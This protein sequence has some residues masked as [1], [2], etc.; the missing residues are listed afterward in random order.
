M[1]INQGGSR[2]INKLVVVAVN[3][4]CQAIFS[5]KIW[6][7]IFALLIILNANSLYIKDYSTGKIPDYAIL[8]SSY[9]CMAVLVINQRMISKKIVMTALKLCMG[10]G[11]FVLILYAVNPYNINVNI[12]WLLR[13]AVLILY[14]VISKSTS[15]TANTF[16]GININAIITNI[17]LFFIN[18][19]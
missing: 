16:N 1:C 6:L 18:S 17:T 3:D 13:V 19:P 9:I 11:I 14:F 10:V 2:K 15:L 12:Q 4:I 8:V 5:K 7:Y